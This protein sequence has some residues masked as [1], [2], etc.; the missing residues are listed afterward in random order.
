MTDCAEGLRSVAECDGTRPNDGAWAPSTWGPNGRGAG[1][2]NPRSGRAGMT[3]DEE[4][5][6]IALS[7]FDPSSNLGPTLEAL[8]SQRVAMHRV[9]FIALASTARSILTKVEAADTAGRAAAGDHLADLLTDLTPVLLDGTAE[10]DPLV[11]TPRLLHSR[12]TGWRVPALWGNTYA[13][14]H[15]LHLVTDL[16]R[17]VRKGAA[18]LAVESASVTEQWHCTRILLE[19]SS[20]PVLALEYS[21][22][23]NA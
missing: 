4:K 23:P 1:G 9:G 21:L 19:K 13:P 12:R 14:E 8:L 15:E 20:S 5:I 16:E 10:V 2:A 17:Q 7:V 18:I 3:V 11:I 6:R 22:P